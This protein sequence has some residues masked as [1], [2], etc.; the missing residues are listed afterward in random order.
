M[1][2]ATLGCLGSIALLVVSIFLIIWIWQS[3]GWWAGLALLLLGGL[4]LSSM[5]KVRYVPDGP[6]PSHAL[7]PPE[8]QRM[9]QSQPMHVQEAV[10]DVYQ[11]IT[12]SRE[13]SGPIDAA[14]KALGSVSEEG[15][16]TLWAYLQVT[17]GGYLLM[18][19]A[20]NRGQNIEEAIDVC[21][22]ALTVVEGSTDAALLAFNLDTLAK[23]YSDR[24][25]GN[26]AENIERAIAY[27]KQVH[28][29]APQLKH[30]AQ[31][32]RSLNT[33][34][35]IYS[36]RIR[37]D[38]AENIE[39]AIEYLSEAKN[40]LTP[41]MRLERVMTLVN[42]GKAYAE[43]IR[44][45]KA[46][47]IEK[48]V[49]HTE[50]ALKL[51]PR[52]QLPLLR[53][54]ALRNLSQSYCERVRGEKSD[55]VERAIEY[56]EETL[57]IVTSEMPQE[58]ARTHYA[59]ARCYFDRIKGDRAANAEKAVESLERALAVLTL[60]QSPGLWGELKRAQG[61]AY[62]N[63]VRGVRS[64]N[65]ERALSAFNEALT[66]LTRER[67]PL[68]YTKVMD[69]LAFLYS[70]EGRW[71][72]C[73]RTSLDA[74]DV[75]RE[76]FAVHYGDAGRLAVL[77]DVAY[78]HVRAARSAIDL[79]LHGDALRLLEA[80]KAQL[81][82]Q[83]MS[84]GDSNLS[85]LEEK[86][87]LTLRQLRDEVRGLEYEFRSAG[88]N[89]GRSVRE[90][91]G[92]KRSLL[93]ELLSE[94]RSKYPDFMPEGL[95]LDD[96]LALIPPDGALVTTMFS[97]NWGNFVFVVPHGTRAITHEHIIRLDDSQVDELN[98]VLFG[99]TER[100]GWL[101]HYQARETTEQLFES[102]SDLG[103]SMW[104][105]YA[106]AIHDRMRALKL[107]HILC[108]PQSVQS[109]LPLHAAWREVDGGPRYV[110]DDYLVT[111]TPSM[112]ALRNSRRLQPEGTEALI[113]GVSEYKRM[114][115][116]A[117][118][119]VEA[120]NIAALFGTEPI[121]DA[122]ASVQ[123]LQAAMDG[124]HYV[125]LAC[126]GGFEAGDPFSSSLYLGNDDK[127]S[128]SE[129]MASFRL[130]SARLAVLSAC[131]T[132]VVD[133]ARAPSEF[134]GL[135]AGFMQAGARA[136]VS[137][138]WT[139]DDRSTALLMERLYKNHLQDG[140][141]PA[142]ALRE[143][144]IWLRDA[145]AR[146]IGEHFQSFLLPRMSHSEAAKAFG[147]TMM[148]FGPNEQPYA[149]PYYWAPFTYNGA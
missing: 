109:L 36:D 90:E 63:R 141:E 140:L 57:G 144:Q 38:K 97:E 107:Q 126:H 61:V 142:V 135:P 106:G 103:R 108:V 64:E 147:E 131:E 25:Q 43:R 91:L 6:P 49:A 11:P 102:I 133:F 80:G 44:D 66:V 125:H 96:I 139:V 12:D 128:L 40:H 93:Q 39:L 143:S 105:A 15:N 68:E 8:V 136:V 127:V 26:M 89:V 33:L 41:E 58:W 50:E 77:T 16:A 78:R 99:T 31:H 19:P 92:V 129:I 34:G 86:E 32:V 21:E 79:G 95:S 20:G 37:G 76:A 62:R 3:W 115:N 119:R 117:N 123:A 27:L 71:E 81:L 73:Y 52:N 148:R 55:N 104:D 45:S 17:L 124:K 94:L 122:S 149:H 72:E 48:V 2:K 75:G 85:T 82:G 132:G 130:R 145:T 88:P 110:I 35:L 54:Q 13:L 111:Y 56:A 28:S 113:A 24:T 69:N 4:A 7:V 1:K 14:R 120:E 60:T 18:Y 101:R 51:M 114:E 118:A 46:D 112:V 138:L 9:L 87:R 74:I 134:L 23:A 137:S 30:P 42:L 121:V 53:A 47:N 146:D 59:I 116:L 67:D 83:V 70:D 65:V 10:R 22:R 84:V 5:V 29:L 100:P 98:G